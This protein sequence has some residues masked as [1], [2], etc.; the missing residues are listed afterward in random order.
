[1]AIKVKTNKE[2]VVYSDASDFT[3]SET[4]GVSVLK[5]D[6]VIGFHPAGSYTNVRLVRKDDPSAL[7]DE[8]REIIS[9]VD[10]GTWNAQAPEWKE[11]AENLID[12][13]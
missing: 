2:D 11:R 10:G 12:S 1:M 5:G 9:T 8:A 3:V 6:K 13:L 7:V 4:N